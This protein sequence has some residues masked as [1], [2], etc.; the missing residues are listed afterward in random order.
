MKDLKT[1]FLGAS[2]A[3]ADVFL[4]YVSSED[5]DF[6]DWKNYLRPVLLAVFGYLVADAKKSVR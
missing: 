2:L 6:S 1:T 5:F 4:N 3:G